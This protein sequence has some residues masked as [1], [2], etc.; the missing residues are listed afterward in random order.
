MSTFPLEARAP[1]VHSNQHYRVEQSPAD[2]G[3]EAIAA[4]AAI[5]Q[6]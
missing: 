4:G 1:P 6:A 2:G 3:A 5:A